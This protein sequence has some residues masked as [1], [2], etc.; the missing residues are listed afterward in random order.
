MPSAKLTP[1]CPSTDNGCNVIV[2]RDPPIS[3]FGAK[4]QAYGNVAA[5]AY[6]VSP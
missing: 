2:R 4:T 6:V 1:I 5:D 3:T